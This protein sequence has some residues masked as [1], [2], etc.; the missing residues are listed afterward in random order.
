MQ[1]SLSAKIAVEISWLIIVF[2]YTVNVLLFSRFY[3]RDS[4]RVIIKLVE[5]YFWIQ[6][7]VG[8][9]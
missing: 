1:I 3:S 2:N 7:F 8:L 4:Q 6:L 5:D 9:L